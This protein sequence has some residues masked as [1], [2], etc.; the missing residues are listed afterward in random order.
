MN[1]KL[2]Y[3]HVQLGPSIVTTSTHVEMPGGH[4]T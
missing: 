2:K 4:F 3:V 1:F